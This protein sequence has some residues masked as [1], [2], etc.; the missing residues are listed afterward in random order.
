MSFNVTF[1]KETKTYDKPISVLEIVGNDKDIICAYVNRRVRELTYVIDKDSEIVPLTCKDRDAKP[2]YEAS[3][4]FLVAMAM[5]NI[6][7]D[8]EIRFSYNISRSIFMQIL[9]PNMHSNMQ[10]VRD[11]EEEM[12]KIVAADLP[13]VR[14]IVNKEE[15]AKIFAKEGFKDKVDILKYR[16]EKTAHIYTCGNYKN[17]MN[18]QPRLEQS[19]HDPAF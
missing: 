9:T 2:S 1:N 19:I 12:K 4:R 7:P 15:A 11:L 18:S 10:M 5:H 3:L 17:Y 13:L 8:L 14:N 16:P 6:R